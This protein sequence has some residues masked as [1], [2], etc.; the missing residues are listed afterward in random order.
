MK[1]SDTYSLKAINKPDSLKQEV[2]E[3]IKEA[4]ITNQFAPAQKLDETKIGEVLGVS[5]TPVREAF[6]RLTFEGLAYSSPNRGIFV[7]RVTPADLIEILD[8]REVLEG[9]AARLFTARSDRR[10]V[11]DLSVIMEPFTVE[12]VER[13]S[14]QY[15]IANVDFHNAVID[16]AGNERL[17]RAL[18]SLYDHLA[19]AKELKLISTTN[20][21]RRSLEQHHRVIQAISEGDPVHAETLMRSHIASLRDD[22]ISRFRA[23]KRLL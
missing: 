16:G 7:A 9:L 5:R 18:T 22:V 10:M 21:A 23:D 3:R 17:S 12:N 11:S 14:E 8:I 1:E 2:Y 6:N 15:A 13:L 20:R 19:L 4:I